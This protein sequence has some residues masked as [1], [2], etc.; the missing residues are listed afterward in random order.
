MIYVV[1][2][3]EL[4]R[5]KVGR[6]DTPKARVQNMR[7]NS[8]CDLELL[9]T[10]PGGGDRERKVQS[11]LSKDHSHGEWY[12]VSRERAEAVLEKHRMDV[13]QTSMFDGGT[14]DKKRE[15]LSRSEVYEMADACDP[16]SLRGQRDRAIL[17]MGFDLAMRRSEVV[18][19]QFGDVSINE[20][21][22][23]V[24]IPQVRSG[25]ECMAR[26]AF[27]ER[28]GEYCPAKAV[29]RWL[30]ASGVEGGSIF[31]GT[32]RWGNVSDKAVT[33]AILNRSVVKPHAEAIGIAADK[34]SYQA[35]RAG[36][37]AEMVEAGEAFDT[38]QQVS[39]LSVT[40]IYNYQ[41]R[42]A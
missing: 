27:V 1:Y 10:I 6:S 12:E 32:D 21:G 3:D 34:V 31:R 38:I 39:G 40:Q 28:K 41:E 25:T 37:I 26:A 35:V 5:A 20:R 33:G 15:A 9:G 7:V 4:G 29:G 2:A 24:D 42:F 22:L 14:D 18:A 8:P 23:E 13:A 11:D 16:S 17:L 19:L 36:R 30:Q